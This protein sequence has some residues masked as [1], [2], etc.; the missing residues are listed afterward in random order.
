MFYSFF[1]LT[2]LLEDVLDGL[3]HHPI[4]NIVTDDAAKQNLVNCQYLNFF[5]P[6]IAAMV[7]ESESGIHSG[8]NEGGLGS[9]LAGLA[10]RR[11]FAGHVFVFL[12]LTSI[13]N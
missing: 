10:L 8:A 6:G 7:E 9:L 2:L 3:Y 12:S 11:R 4:L 13:S 1:Q 5:L